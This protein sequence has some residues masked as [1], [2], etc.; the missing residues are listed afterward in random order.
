MLRF[1]EVRGLDFDFKANRD[2]T[3]ES[4]R[5]GTSQTE[6]ELRS[7]LIGFFV[8][9]NVAKIY[10]VGKGGGRRRSAKLLSPGPGSATPAAA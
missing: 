4:S 5:T 1:G 9:D 3:A 6:V 10:L 8:I 2:C 7:C